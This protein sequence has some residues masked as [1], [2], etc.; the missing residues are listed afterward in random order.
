MLETLLRPDDTVER[1]GLILKN[2]DV[3]EVPNIATDPVNSYEMDPV[4][5]LKYLDQVE[6]TWHTHPTS[7]AVLSHE[8]R[9]GFVAWPDWGHVIIGRDLKGEV[10][11]AK[12]VVEDGLVIVCD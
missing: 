3:I 8:D 7:N 11:V 2:G 10:V 12:Y 4:E 9:D 5:V 6:A 1:C